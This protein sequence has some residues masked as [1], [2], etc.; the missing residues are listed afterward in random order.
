VETETKEYRAGR[1]WGLV[2]VGV[3]FSTKKF[4]DIDRRVLG[5]C[6]YCDFCTILDVGHLWS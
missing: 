2:F 1:L 4:F 3:S 6:L 5:L